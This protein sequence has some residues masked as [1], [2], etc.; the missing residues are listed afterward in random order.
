MIVELLPACGGLA[1]TALTGDAIVAALQPGER[2]R[3]PARRAALGFVVGAGVSTLVLFVGNRL[4]LPLNRASWI[5]TQVLLAA[6]G[7]LVARRRRLGLTAP[8]RRSPSA[9][10]EG[11]APDG[12]SRLLLL[13]TAAVT[14]G[15]TLV[16][17]REQAAFIDARTVWMLGARVLDADAGFDGSYWSEWDT[18]TDRRDYPPL[19]PLLGSG[20]HAF[21]GTP[22]DHAVKLAHMAWLASLLIL[23]HGASRAA[24]G[25]R[26]AA[27]AAL[28]FAL[29]GSTLTVALWG[30]ADL[31]LATSVL[32][33]L[34]LLLEED[35]VDGFGASR[36][37][38]V[39]VIAATVVFTKTEGAP[40]VGALLG[41]H[42]L[43]RRQRPQTVGA[44]PWSHSVVPMLA[45]PLLALAAWQ[46]FCHAHGFESRAFQHAAG[47]SLIEELPDRI[48]VT[49]AAFFTE[50]LAPRWLWSWP[51][52]LLACWPRRSAPS[53]RPPRGASRVGLAAFVVLQLAA[54]FLI[55]VLALPD[56][57]WQL[58]TSL[59]RVVFHVWPAAWLLLLLTVMAPREQTSASVRSAVP[60]AVPPATPPPLG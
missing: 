24:L 13:A 60:S 47:S 41:A 34:V 55:Y 22:N 59:P 5:V 33:A 3:S 52:L 56:T 31:P 23:L 11:A 26:A 57:A 17:V 48:S 40:A 14:L 16:S 20:M 9:T 28:L 58:Q 46:A 35:P 8:G 4:G 12:V 1:L 37:A 29:S 51:L 44:V 45:I 43:H 30:T 50:A 15:L 54:Y 19:V 38:L 10:S 27:L 18:S 42:L 25:P 32:A 2:D 7:V 6:L 53:T 21:S 39:G 36:F 49:L